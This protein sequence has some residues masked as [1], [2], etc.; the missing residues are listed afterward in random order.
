[1]DGQ[2]EIGRA[3]P[4][5]SAL[6]A[7]SGL[8]R[9]PVAGFAL[10]CIAFGFLTIEHAVSLF[11][12]RPNLLVL[13]ES[14]LVSEDYAA[15]PGSIFATMT[16]LYRAHIHGISL[17]MSLGGIALILG[18]GQF[19]P[20]LRRQYP[21]LHRVSGIAVI[22]AGAASMIGAMVFLGSIEMRQDYSGPSFHFGLWALAGLTLCVLALAVHAIRVRD[23][24][25]HMGWMAAAFAALLTAPL[26]RLEWIASG[27][28]LPY[29]QE[30]NNLASSITIL[31]QALL[32]MA[33]WNSLRRHLRC[34][35]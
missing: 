34:S 33:L 17:H 26:L 19:I 35:R 3:W 21:R 10:I 25:A 32:L 13:L 27:W 7:L 16:P 8:L 1:M 23:R 14:W 30:Q 20:A 5:A 2:G 6:R 11:D 28:F 29:A 18:V 4:S 12:V 15:G 31:P 22:L 24:R 9:V